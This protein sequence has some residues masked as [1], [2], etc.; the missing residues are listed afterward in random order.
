MQLCAVV[1]KDELATF[2]RE[3]TPFELELAGQSRR[4]ISLGRPSRIE[5]VAG[6]GL[7][8]GGAARV[9]WDIAGLALPVA[10]RRWQVLLV[11]SIAERGG[12]QVLAFDP[13]LEELSMEHV[14]GFVDER[15]TTAIN[16]GLSAQKARL[17]WNFTRTLSWRRALPVRFKPTSRFE[18]VPG[19]ARVE[20]TGSEIRLSVELRA[21][22]VRDEAAGERR[23]TPSSRSA[24]V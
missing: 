14:P 20:V 2:V 10:L 3:S 8:I 12:A 18:L 6:A 19:A 21:R 16:D 13:R 24:R 15:I 11:P 9:T 22:L 1:T 23:D 4:K 5:L 7:R 17:A